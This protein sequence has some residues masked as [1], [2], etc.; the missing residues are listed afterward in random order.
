VPRP[1]N[2][3]YANREESW[4][5]FNRRVLEQARNTAN[6]LLER[7][8][9]LAIVSS[10]LDEFFEIRVAGIMQQADSETPPLSIDGLTPRE[11]LKRIKRDVDTLVHD[12]YA[13]W[14]KELVPALAQ[15]KIHFRT[16][17]QLDDVEKAWVQT[18]FDTQVFPVLTPLAVDQA[19]PFP[20]L[21]NKTLNVLISLDHPE[22]PDTEKLMVIVPVPRSLPRIVQIGATGNEAP[23]RHVFLSE[24]IK[25]CAGGLFPGYHVRGAHA[26]RVTRNSDLYID[27]EESA[28]LLKKIEEELRNLRRGAAVRLEI[29]EGVDE[30]LFNVLCSHVG[31]ATE[32]AFRMQG[33]LNLLRLFSLY[34]LI[35]RP[36]LKYAPFTP[37]THPSFAHKQI[38]EALRERDVL[39]H[40]PY[41]SFAPVVEFIEAA[42]RDPDVL[43]IK[44]TL[45]R[46]SGD[47]PVVRALIDASMAGKQVTA[48]VELMARFDEANNIKW[49]RELEDAGVHVVYGL[50]G[51][52][53]H[54]K[55]CLVVRR[56]GTELRR[57]VHLGTG[58]YNPKT[59]RLYT[60]LSLLTSRQ[61]LALEVA[62][63]FNALTGHGRSPEFKELMV[64]PFNLHA[65]IQSLIAAETAN[66]AA[67]K[68]ARIIAKMNKLV[69]PVTIDGLYAASQAGVKI[70]L[71]VRATCCL[72]PGVKG[73]S[74]NIRLR[75]IVGR[76]LEHARILYFENG[77]E[78]LVYCSSADWMPRN[79]FR[80]VET[81]YPIDDPDL[82]R[83]LINDILAIE[84]RD[85]ED[86]RELQP[87][88]TYVPAKRAEGE[89]SFSAQKYF[90]AEANA[91]A[92]AAMAPVPATVPPAAMAA[93]AAAPV[94]ATA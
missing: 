79:F 63:L 17:G 37:T 16:A 73:L 32:H 47:S 41:D 58:N 5:A 68:P 65:R 2:T 48:L 67:G 9:F 59:A 62:Q 81:V 12:Q 28:N 33:P 57:Y 85:N 1:G 80:R 20:Q 24:I 43:A 76:F 61:S 94:R 13:C 93:A 50:V 4:L 3:T 77:G 54:C 15:H 34:D 35:D 46:T 38:F 91:R 7:V 92:A 39:L 86:A 70:D 83:R 71:I 52:K 36:D 72:R 66:A 40:H 55:C 26:F 51:H 75:N 8:K 42:A 60:D 87:D 69:D 19:H 14:H 45:Y 22:T 74:E 82:R 89:P 27:E 11:Q 56:E 44:Q 10:N 78:P 23:L 21:G 29:E 31:I 30:E 88:G 18:Y 90:M 53:T 49:A 64:A 6:P 25:L 84:L